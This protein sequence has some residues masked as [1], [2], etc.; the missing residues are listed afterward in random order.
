[1]YISF[2]FLNSIPKDTSPELRDLLLKMLKRNAKDRIEFGKLERTSIFNGNHKTV[3]PVEILNYFTHVFQRISSSILSSNHQGNQLQ[4][5]VSIQTTSHLKKKYL[6]IPIASKSTMMGIVNV[7][8]WLIP[9][10]LA[11]PVPVPGRASQGCSSESPTPPR[12]VSASPLSGKADYSTPP[13]KVTLLWC[14]EIWF[15]VWCCEWV[16]LEVYFIVFGQVSRYTREEGSVLQF[17][18]KFESVIFIN[19][20]KN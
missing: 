4:H 3:Y 20:K 1:M 2:S 7:G 19:L 6:Y 9:C 13:S 15:S 11:S 14:T 10:I 5:H 18:K 12:C 17:K 16:F 8:Y